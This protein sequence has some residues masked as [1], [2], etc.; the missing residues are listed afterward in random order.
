MNAIGE[1]LVSF[2]C[3]FLLK[4]TGHIKEISHIFGEYRLV[5]PS[6]NKNKSWVGTFYSR[7]HFIGQ[8]YGYAYTAS[9]KKKFFIKKCIASSF[10]DRPS[11]MTTSSK[12]TELQ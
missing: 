6:H 10:W 9:C 3:Y 2:L 1:L 7:K 5:Y 8:K 11:A 4:K 12:L